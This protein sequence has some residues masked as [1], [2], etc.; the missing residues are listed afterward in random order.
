MPRYDYVCP[1]CQVVREIQRSF[2][3]DKEIL[4]ET[5][6]LPLAKKFSPSPVHFKGSGWYST[7]NK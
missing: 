4:C 6:D 5:C 1:G 2:D 3:D 7:D